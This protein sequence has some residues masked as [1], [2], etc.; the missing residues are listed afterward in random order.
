MNISE[1]PEKEI[2]KNF[3]C[4]KKNQYQS[5]SLQEV[6]KRH[7]SEIEQLKVSNTL[8]SFKVMG[9]KNKIKQGFDSHRE[10]IIRKRQ[11]EDTNVSES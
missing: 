2:K 9:K 6:R 5:K 3:Q 1:S 10:T 7:N 4:L 8:K 11:I